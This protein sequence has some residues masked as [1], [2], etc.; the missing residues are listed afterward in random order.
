MGGTRAA[1]LLLLAA[2]S[3]LT[4]TALAIPVNTPEQSRAATHTHTPVESPTLLQDTKEARSKDIPAMTKTQVI[5]VADAFGQYTPQSEGVGSTDIISTLLNGLQ[6]FLTQM[7]ED[8]LLPD[9]RWPKWVH[10]IQMFVSEVQHSSL[11]HAIYERMSRREKLAHLGPSETGDV[12]VEVTGVQFD[13]IGTV[14]WGMIDGFHEFID[15]PNFFEWWSRF[16]AQRKKHSSTTTTSTMNP[17]S[18]F[19]EDQMVLEE[20]EKDKDKLPSD[21]LSVADYD[22][23]VVGVNTLIFAFYNYVFREY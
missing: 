21:V 19:Y 9:R 7:E 13:P 12:D 14:M 20:K 2:V 18:I 8:E 10:D 16:T 6:G 15:L 23:Y 1:L 11:L 4:P 5:T 3:T 22:P 17:L